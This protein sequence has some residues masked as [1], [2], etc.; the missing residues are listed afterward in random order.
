VSLN[1]NSSN[2]SVHNSRSHLPRPQLS[3]K[4]ESA[5]AASSVSNHPINNNN[6]TIASNVDTSSDEDDNLLAQCISTGKKIREN[7]I[8]KQTTS[9][10]REIKVVFWFIYVKLTVY[11]EF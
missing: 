11:F 2:A 4:S 10:L 7:R 1:S 8:S 5:S 9:F 6:D 3:G